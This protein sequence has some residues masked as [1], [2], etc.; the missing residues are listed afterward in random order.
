MLNGISQDTRSENKHLKEEY[1]LT[2]CFDSQ[3]ISGRV[4]E[5]KGQV[6]NNDNSTD[7]VNIF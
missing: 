7:K 4:E 3:E 5:L 2:I 1:N 6:E